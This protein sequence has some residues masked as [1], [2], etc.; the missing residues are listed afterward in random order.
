MCKR[1]EVLPWT[2]LDEEPVGPFPAEPPFG[3]P[4][5]VEQ[6]LQRI[7]ELRRQEGELLAE[8]ERLRAETLEEV[9][10]RGDAQAALKLAGGLP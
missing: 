1:D 3:S 5:A 2:G 4:E 9:H 8:V 10:M 6:A 7:A